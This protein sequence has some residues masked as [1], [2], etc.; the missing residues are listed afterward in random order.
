MTYSW[1]QISGSPSVRLNEANKSIATF[2]IPFNISADSILIFRLTVSNEKN[3][4]S[5]DG[6]KITS[7]YLPA[8]N[9][10]PIANAGTDRT[11][12]AS[13]GIVHLNAS[14]SN[15][16]DNDLLKYTWVQIGVPRVKL[17]NTNTSIAAFTA[18][19][20][21]SADTNLIFKLTVKDDKNATG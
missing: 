18:P 5:S 10:P 19:F 21:I 13:S 17:D 9:E 16:P 3:S 2:T 1:T 4:S 11:V 7:K 12:N 15:D 20:N 6:V 14:K 8:P